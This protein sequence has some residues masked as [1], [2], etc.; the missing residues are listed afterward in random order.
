MDLLHP[1]PW[2]LGVETEFTLWRFK[3]AA[4]FLYIRKREE[5]RMT[6]T[7]SDANTGARCSL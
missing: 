3:L 2:Q 5:T 7:I 6:G 1:L 4:I